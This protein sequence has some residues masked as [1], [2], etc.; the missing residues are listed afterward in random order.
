MTDLTPSVPLLPPDAQIYFF[1]FLNNGNYLGTASA[2]YLLR[3]VSRY[4]SNAVVFLYGKAAG[5]G[6][7]CRLDGSPICHARAPRCFF[8]PHLKTCDNAR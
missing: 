6:L 5:S 2:C 8:S 7:V 3:K 4:T 1:A